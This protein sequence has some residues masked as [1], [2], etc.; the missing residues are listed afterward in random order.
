MSITSTSVIIKFDFCTEQTVGLITKVVGFVK[1]KYLIP[2]IDLLDLKANPRS[3]KTG[4]VT[5]AIQES[6]ET[7]PALFPFKTKGILLA[8][9]RYERLER[10]RIKIN[11]ENFA[12]EG[13]LDGGH[14]TLA[15]GLHI[16]KKSMLHVGRPF[17]KGEKT[18]DIFKDLWVENRSCIDQY[19]EDVR[20]DSS[21]GNLSF[22][23]PVELLIPRDADDVACVDD[24]KNNL[25]E[26]CEAR[27]NNAELNISA[28]ANQKG[29][30]DALKELMR[31][32]DAALCD[33]IE[34]K[35]NDGGDVKVQDLIALTWIP[36]SLISPVHDEGGK[37]LEPISANKLYSAKGS[38][39]KQFERLMASP[40]VTIKS[41]SDYRRELKNVE[42]SSAFRLA[43]ELPELYDYIYEKF[44]SLYNA[45]DGK[46]GRI[47]AVKKLN[48]S[49]K[50]KKSPFLSRPIDILTPEGYIM[51]LVYGLQAL[52]TKKVTNGHTEIV[53]SQSP[54]VF[55][56]AN[57]EKIVKYY[58]G[59][60]SIC[61]YDPQKVGKNAQSYE[62]ALAGFKMAVAN[63]L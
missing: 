4:P 9:S 60:I 25:L 47:T 16:L 7:D 51:P 2:V 58:S 22:F 55:L 53:W 45:A 26:I 1:A 14:N 13:I 15:I 34:W 39:L 8:S 18:W 17:P 10:G 43:V 32:R 62:Q 36:L 21:I 5:N 6:I 49:R 20:A 24:F 42:V 57:L 56:Q 41:G 31:A 33:R 29:Y 52:M 12:I 37:L 28:K 48:E 38:C 40:E 35:T 3:S 19:L 61:D 63:I 50:D 27:N 54:T 30:F 46:Y 44:P 59:I 11:P 23:V